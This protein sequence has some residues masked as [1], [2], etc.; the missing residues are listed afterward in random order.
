MKVRIAKLMM[1]AS[2][3]VAPLLVGGQSIVSA[4]TSFPQTGQKVWG[5]F[6][7]YWKSHGGLA[8]FGMARTSV[9]PAKD[10]N[11]LYDAQWFERA[12][13]TYNPSHPDP[14]KVE[15]ALLGNIVTAD[16]RAKGE[17]PFLKAAPGAGMPT[18]NAG[19][20]LYFPQTGHNISGKFLEYWKSNGGLPIYGYPI[21]EAFMEVSRS[22][23]KSYMVQ[24]FE[25]N[26]L[27]L[28]PEA[29]GTPY[30]VQLGL[31]G[32]ELLDKQGG[33]SAFANLGSPHFYPPSG[34]GSGAYPKLGHAPDYSWVAGQV[35]V[36]R[37]QGGCV[38]V[39]SDT[40]QFAPN[41]QAWEGAQL[42][43]GDYVVMFGHIAKQGEPI[44]V[45]PGGTP[46]IV[47]R[48]MANQ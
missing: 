44:A 20:Y 3:L 47:D 29:A 48:V 10:G 34:S 25:R 15:L 30:E 37:I 23:G 8:Q 41:G 28:H 27:E 45:C 1:A 22:D 11:T 31:L 2:V 32:S 33:P 43:D 38:F 36:T 18:A 13:F 12:L 4:D 42:K 46:Y 21:S 5:P 7:T 6:E 24:Y 40:Q 16:R 39:K 35:L 26:R 14:Y 19:G 17:E 9:Y